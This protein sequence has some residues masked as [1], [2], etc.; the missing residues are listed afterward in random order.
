MRRVF[1]GRRRASA[2]LTRNPPEP[3]CRTPCACPSHC[4]QRIAET[5]DASGR[6]SACPATGGSDSE[7]GWL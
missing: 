1:A 3:S 2:P 4:T 5:S 7:R 6:S